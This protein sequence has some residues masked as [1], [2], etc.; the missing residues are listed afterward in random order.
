MKSFP[1][2]LIGRL[3]V[4]LAFGNQGI[5]SQ[6]MDIIKSSCLFESGNRCRFLVVDAYNLPEVLK[7]YQRNDFSF[8]FSTEDQEKEYFELANEDKIKTR[9][10]YYDLLDWKKRFV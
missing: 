7:Y 8:V 5:G 9:L 1:A 3:G 4:S 2:T 10:M 6:L